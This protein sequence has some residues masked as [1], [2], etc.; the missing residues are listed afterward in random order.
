MPIDSVFV[1]SINASG[2][3]HEYTSLHIKSRILG[4]YRTNTK[5]CHFYI[6]FDLYY[7][8][9]LTTS[10]FTLFTLFTMLTW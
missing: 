8:N 2:D 7:Q 9:P 1:I 5:Q 6:Q 10:F 4:T 3:V